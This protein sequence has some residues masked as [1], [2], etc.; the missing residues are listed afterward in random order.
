MAKFDFFYTGGF[1]VFNKAFFNEVFFTDLF[2][3]RLKVRGI[4]GMALFTVAMLASDHVVIFGLFD[5]HDFV[6]APFSSSGNAPNVQSNVIV[7]IIIIP[8]S[9]VTRCDFSKIVKNK[10]E[11]L[12][13]NSSLH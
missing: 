4:S 9:R 3:L 5:H 12:Q 1:F 6:N 2:L 8:M 13:S 7:I 10:T 11:A